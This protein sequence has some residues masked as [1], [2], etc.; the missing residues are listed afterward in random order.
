MKNIHIQKNY[1][2]G[3]I[4]GVLFNFAEALM[5]PK[6]VLPMLISTL[7]NSSFIV[8]LASA[9]LPA[10]WFLPQIFVASFLEGKPYKKFMYIYPAYA[11]FIAMLSMSILIFLHPPFI[12]PA[13]L[14][15]LFIY[16]L[17]GG[18]GG[19]SFMDIVG[20]TIAPAKLP[21]FWGWRQ[22][23]GGIMAAGGG[24]IV[25]YVLATKD[26][27]YNYSILFFL[28]AIII[29]FGLSAF[30]FTEE[31]ED[32]C[33]EKN[34]SFKSFL[35]S[36]KEI[37]KKDIQYRKLF[38]L[39]ILI[40]IAAALNPFYILFALRHNIINTSQAGY[41]I[42]AQMI[43]MILSNIIWN[44]IAKK[45]SVREVLIFNSIL[46]T[47]MPALIFLAIFNFIFLYILFFMIG[48]TSAA[49]R[50]GYPSFLLSI[51]PHSKRPTYIGVMNTLTGPFFFFSMVNGFL[52]D[53]FSFTPVIILTIIA[54]LISLYIAFTLKDPT[55]HN[56]KRTI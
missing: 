24:F 18:L 17:A 11:R 51:A 30:A 56:E 39:R 26:Y 54:G 43:G 52:I 13:L 40:N 55:I 16:A 9:M 34:E 21:S 41:L 46:Y 47:L 3:I 29:A 36:G 44:Y 45:K 8:G 5:G 31:P 22:A 50:I 28:S 10:L 48:A 53:V 49:T 2:L 23:V 19:V 32:K 42:T 35:K 6:T 33:Q 1:I 12:L 7:T 15:L 38:F 4:N 27:P 37:F 14:I 20:K 25:K